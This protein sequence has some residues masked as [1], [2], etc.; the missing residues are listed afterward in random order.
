MPEI[1][2]EHT[3]KV[4][5][6]RFNWRL[7]LYFSGIKIFPAEDIHIDGDTYI[8]KYDWKM[9]PGSG[10]YSFDPKDIVKGESLILRRRHDWWAENEQW[11]KNTY[12]FEQIKFKVV[13]ERELTYEKFKADELD[14]FRVMRSQRWVQEVPQEKSV[15]MGWIQGRKV[16][17]KAP[18]GF[19]GFAFNMRKPPFKD[20]RVRL[21]F[22]Y[23]FNVKKLNERLFFNQYLKIRSYFPGRDWGNGDKNPRI[24]YNPDKAEELL[25]QAGYKERNEDG[26]L[27]NAEGKPLEVTLE[28]GFKSQETY[29][30]A[31][32][33]DWEDAG[34]KLNLELLDST[35]VYKHIQARQFSLYF[36]SWGGLVF[37]NPRTSWSSKL[38]D[39]PNNNNLTGFK[40]AEVDRLLEEYDIALERSKQKQ[41]TKKIDSLVFNEHPYALGWYANFERILYWDRMGHP[42]TYFTKTGQDPIAEVLQGWWWDPDKIK[43]LKEARKNGTVLKPNE[44]LTVKPWEKP[45]K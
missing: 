39:K 2:D 10:P 16:H 23:L 45:V 5:T 38:A 31:I 8:K 33:K 17:N 4:K 15:K 22:A 35:T 36:Q 1:V 42:K 43:T 41:I 13:L 19:S 37:P 11:A 24:D 28:Y 14:L 20:R 18:E 3:I 30:L 7:F 44:L 26:W 29:L 9:I 27:V 12:N 21:A 6:K 25:F 34:I 40:N 32:Q